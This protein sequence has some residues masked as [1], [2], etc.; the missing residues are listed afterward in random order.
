MRQR[1]APLKEVRVWRF[2]LYYFLVFGGFVALAGWLTPYY[3]SVYAM[4]LATAGLM[5]SIFAWPASVIRA[6][7]GWM[8]DRFGARRVMYWVLFTCVAGFA[9]LCVPRMEIRSPGE[10][11]LA[12][13]PGTVK[14][15][16]ADRVVVA[17]KAG[18]ESVYPLRKK[19]E[20]FRTL[21]EQDA[22]VLV[23]PSGTSWQEPAV[24]VGDAVK[25]KQV[26]ARGTTHIYFQ[27]NVWIFTAILFLVGVMMGI[28]KAAVYKHIPEYFPDAVPVVGSI[29]GVIGGLGGFVGPILFG[30]ML[31][32]TGI[33]TTCW[34]FFLILSI[35]CLAW[36]HAVIRNMI[37]RR[38][39]AIAEHYED[40]AA[41]RDVGPGPVAMPGAP[42]AR[43]YSTDSPPVAAAA[44]KGGP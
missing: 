44:A 7:G 30:T 37:A 23:L 33:W 15:A 21:A 16:S 4:S 24:A 22:D 27:A 20:G 9:L 41:T 26:L 42:V 34:V 43:A 28:G 2:G 5:T 19:P 18:T 1:L 40:R 35:V 13:K 12:F 11:V 39:P 32:A 36:M 31:Q 14:V 17:D 25:P 29:V 8:S 10:G 38:A 6:L 3:V